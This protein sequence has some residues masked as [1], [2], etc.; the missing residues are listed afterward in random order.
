MATSEPWLTL[1]RSVEAS[2]AILHNPTKEIYVVGTP[3]DLRAFLILDLTGPLPGYIQTICVAPTARYQGLGTGL[4]AFAE[5]R[6]WGVSPN[7]FLC[8]SSF[9]PAAMRLYERLGYEVIGTL[10]GYL[11]PEHDEI[12]LRKTLGPWMA[13][14]TGRDA[15]RDAGSAT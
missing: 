12:L 2:L 3:S 13:F 10:R 6:I 8:V 11:V 9:N 5:R 1:G 15:R 7:V 4:I 14:T